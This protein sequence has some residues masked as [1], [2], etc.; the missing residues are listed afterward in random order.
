ML[1]HQSLLAEVGLDKI[2]S[3]D[4]LDNAPEAVQ[5]ENNETRPRTTS[6]EGPNQR[7][8]KMK[9]VRPPALQTEK[10]SSLSPKK[11]EIL[12]MTLDI[13]NGKLENIKLNENDDPSK[14][15]W[16]FCTRHGFGKEVYEYLSLNIAQNLGLAIREKRES[17]FLNP[18]RTNISYSNRQN[19]KTPPGDS[20]RKESKEFSEKENIDETNLSPKERTNRS[21]MNTPLKTPS[22]QNLQRSR[23]PLKKPEKKKEFK[24]VA[25][26]KR[27]MNPVSFNQKK[28]IFNPEIWDKLYYDGIRQK[29]TKQREIEAISKMMKEKE[30]EELSFTP[31]INEISVKI[32]EMIKEKRGNKKTE[33]FLLEQGNKTKKKVDR[34]RKKQEEKEISYPFCPTINPISRLI[35]E[36][37][38]VAS[39]SEGDSMIK[40]HTK[41]QELHEEWKAKDAKMKVLVEKM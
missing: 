5:P 2:D 6:I 31:A 38:S 28:N 27:E 41:F 29:E 36:D 35:I 24:S 17:I 37:K 20:S 12:V 40:G 33:D 18:S 1:N 34:M 15:A 10:I 4:E 7:A 22:Q 23:S 11:K 25:T 8:P 9:P 13:G 39:G 26:R 3:S 32:S 19:Q 30:L 21:G 16:D 14:T